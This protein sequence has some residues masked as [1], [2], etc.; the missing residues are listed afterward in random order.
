MIDKPAGLP[1]A[2][3]D[4]DDPDCLQFFVMRAAR[5]MVWAVH[6][7]DADTSGVNVFVRKR[8]LVPVWQERL[9]FPNAAKSY[10]AIVH[11]P[12]LEDALR[13]AAPIGWIERGVAAAAPDGAAQAAWRGWG[14]SDDGK[15]AATRFEVI[16]RAGGFGLLRCTLET[17]RTHQIRVHLRHLGASLVGEEWY[18]DE[19]CGLHPRQALHAWTI[20]F[21][22]GVEPSELVAPIPADLVELAARLG[23]ELPAQN[24]SRSPI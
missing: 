4:L 22:D 23:L 19:P 2:G 20:R 14:V 6:Q 5:R 21:G 18:R 16:A 7:L 15:P 9:R 11:D 10:L 3:R 1:T 13:V 24:S 12:P 17:G 8:S